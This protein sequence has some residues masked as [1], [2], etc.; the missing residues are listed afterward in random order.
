[1]THRC[2]RL[3]IVVLAGMVS[4]AAAHQDRVLA[5]SQADPQKAAIQGRLK[6]VGADLFSGTT[7]DKVKEA[8]KELKAI[9]ALDPG[10]AEAHMLLGI[11]YR[12]QGSAEL[13]GEAIAE[14]RQALAISPRKLRWSSSRDIPRC[15]PCSARPSGN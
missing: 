7:P 2:F 14:F 12:A 1:M 6:R 13:M 8:T 4:W 11:A 9:L 3:S 10:S 15:S 5:R